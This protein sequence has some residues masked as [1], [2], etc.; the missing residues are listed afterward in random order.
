MP[1]NVNHNYAILKDHSLSEGDIV[2][3]LNYH[4]IKIIRSVA[5][6][7]EGRFILV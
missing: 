3:G 6:K 4:L 5:K 7:I 1:E 2:G